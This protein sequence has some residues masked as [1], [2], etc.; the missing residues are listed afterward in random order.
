MAQFLFEPRYEW[1]EYPDGDDWEQGWHGF[2]CRIRTNP[3]GAE[4]R[5]ETHLFMASNGTDI[6]AQDEYWQYIAPRI[7]EW[8]LAVPGDDGAAVDVPPP[9]EDWES[10]TLLPLNVAIW[11]R[12]CIHVAHTGPKALSR[13]QGLTLPDAVTTTDTTQPTPL[14]QAS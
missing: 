11:I 10:M 12:L 1:I 5:H 4:L 8:N 3:S 14:H 7:I 2:K 13:M 6:A 9:A